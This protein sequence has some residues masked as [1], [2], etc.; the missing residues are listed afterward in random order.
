MREIDWHKNNID[1][2]IEETGNRRELRYIYAIANAV[3]FIL[4]WIEKKE[5]H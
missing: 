4:I 2:V 1:I 3:R 5:R